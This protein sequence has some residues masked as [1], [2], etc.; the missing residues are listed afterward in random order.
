MPK[1]LDNPKFG[2]YCGGGTHLPP[3]TKTVPKFRD[4]FSQ[5]EHFSVE[6]CVGMSFEAQS[7]ISIVAYPT[8]FFQK[9]V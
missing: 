2:G 3:R 4:G 8:V 6:K 5:S 7:K 1:N 9:H